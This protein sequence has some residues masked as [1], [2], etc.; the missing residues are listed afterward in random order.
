[1][2]DRTLVDTGM[3][4]AQETMEVADDVVQALLAA[5]AGRST[6]DQAHVLRSF[7]RHVEG[8]G[9]LYTIQ[10]GQ[11][12]LEQFDGAARRIGMAYQAA[13]DQRTGEAT[14]I[15]RD[16]DLPLLERVV[17]DLAEEGMPLYRDPQ[18]DVSRFLAEHDGAEVMCC[19]SGSME[20]VA[21]GKM[22]A[23]G[24]GVEFAIGRQTDGGHIVL[25][26]QKDHGILK[27]LGI[28][29]AGSTPAPLFKVSDMEDVERVVRE[30]KQARRAEARMEKD[31]EHERQR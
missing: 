5:L 2:D 15:V 4:Y 22:E 9:R 10:L 19:R 7:A 11:G 3:G 18:L 20:Q 8:G 25:F 17:V 23:M 26:L 21:D 1:M 16:R 30:K 6:S 28:V 13:V 27:D 14:I 31:R 29:D 24:K 12:H